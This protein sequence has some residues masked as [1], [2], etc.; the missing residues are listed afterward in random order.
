MGSLVSLLLGL[1]AFLL[2]R[3]LDRVRTLNA[4]LEQKVQ[5][6]TKELKAANIELEKLARHDA[7][8]GLYN[9]RALTDYL[10]YLYAQFTRSHVGYAVLL[11]D[12]DYFKKVND[13]YGHEVGDRVLKG[14][15]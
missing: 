13:Q 9:R 10:D 12:V 11:L 4:T 14:V 7:L 8:T 1:T 3:H 5:E 2:A 15:A 6:R